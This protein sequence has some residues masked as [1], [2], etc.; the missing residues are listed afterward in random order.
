M[1]RFPQGDLGGRPWSNRPSPPRYLSLPPPLVKFRA[2]DLAPNP[3]F[4]LDSQYS[5]A[6]DVTKHM[7]PPDLLGESTIPKPKANQQKFKFNRLS[8]LRQN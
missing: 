3:F 7:S 4:F 6:S 5:E 8:I 2:P 1:G